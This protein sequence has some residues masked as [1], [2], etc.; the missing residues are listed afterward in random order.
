MSDKAKAK[1]ERKKQKAEEKGKELTMNYFITSHDVI[2]EKGYFY[3]IA[4]SYY[5]TYTYIYTGRTSQQVFNGYFYTNAIL[6][7][8]DSKGNVVWDNCFPMQPSYRPY[9]VKHFISA[10]L[11]GNNLNAIFTDG[12]KLVSKSF[13]KV[14]GTV[15]QDR[16]VEMIK[17]GNDDEDV[18]RSFT[19]SDYWYGK[20]FLLYGNQVVKNSATRDRQ[21]VFYLSKYTT[22]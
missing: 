17:T 15:T 1:V 5:P 10:S 18:K 8:F 14:N 20:N 21:H 13:N 11:G 16:N 12:K 6:I 9:S 4:E 7:K 2:E 3:Y 22:K 19:N